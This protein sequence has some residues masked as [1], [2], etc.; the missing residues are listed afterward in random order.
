MEKY[1]SQ[2]VISS[3]SVHPHFVDNNSHANIHHTHDVT[4]CGH[5]V[6]CTQQKRV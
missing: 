2:R 5:V 6:E 3:L 1:N 4:T